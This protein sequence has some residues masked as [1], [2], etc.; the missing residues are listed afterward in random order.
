[1]ASK[2]SFRTCESPSPEAETVIRT[3][4]DRFTKGRSWAIT[5]TWDLD[6]G[7]LIGAMRPLEPPRGSGAKVPFW[8]GPYETQCLFERLADLSREGWADWELH[9]H[10][11]LRPVGYIRRGLCAA[12]PEA[13]VEAAR[14]MGEVIRRKYGV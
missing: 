2:L 12:D 9:D 8:P 10:Y 13:Q 14:H 1:M 5:F 6:D 7:R 4:L 11:G 3:S